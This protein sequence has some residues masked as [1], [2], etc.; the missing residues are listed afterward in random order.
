MLPMNTGAEAVET[1]IKVARKWGY[2]VKGVPAGPG[3]D[4]RRRRQLPRPHHHDHQLL[5][6]PGRARRLRP[7]HARASGSCRTATSARCD[8]AIDE[9]TVAVLVEPIQGE[10]G[11][12]R[13]AGRLPARRCGRCA[14]AHDVLF[15]ADEIQSGLG[16]TG[17]TFACDHEGVVPD[18]YLLGKALGGGIVPVSA[19]VGDR[20]VLGVLQPGRARLDVR[21]QPAGVRRRARG[22]RA[23]RDRRVPGAGARRSARVLH[24]AAAGAGRARRRSTVRGARPV[25]GRRH[26]PGADDRPRGLRA[27]RWRAAC[28]PRTPTAR[29]SGSR[30]RS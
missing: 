18:L 17:A 30:R 20:D 28:W 15:I 13:A 26:R 4:R 2:Q 23:A 24:D 25:G 10:A 12:R 19:V 3:D 9:T 21:R 7:V 8:A 27:A 6:R 1:A 16:R 22:R 11:R 29:R 5:Q 14:R